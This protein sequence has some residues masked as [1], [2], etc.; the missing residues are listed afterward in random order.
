M[1]CFQFVFFFLLFYFVVLLCCVTY[2][3]LSSRHSV[4]ER[5]VVRA[6]ERKLKESDASGW[7]SARASECVC[8]CV[9][10]ERATDPKAK[11]G[12]KV[13]RALCRLLLLLPS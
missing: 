3:E 4:R 8:V 6:G 12:L 7:A 2:Y 11:L 10:R 1:H 5:D 9:H 13:T